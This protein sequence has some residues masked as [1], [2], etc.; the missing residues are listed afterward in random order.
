MLQLQGLHANTDT[1]KASKNPRIRETH[2]ENVINKSFSA[3]ELRG[4]RDLR[5]TEVKWPKQ[6][7]KY[8]YYLYLKHN[9]KTYLML[10][11]RRPKIS[12]KELQW[13]EQKGP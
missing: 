3:Q 10:S 1:E 13:K 8:G 12:V 4:E 9:L 5:S 7:S 2:K 11:T 6:G